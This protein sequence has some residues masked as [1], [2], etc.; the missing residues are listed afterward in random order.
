MN[1]GLITHHWVPNFGANLQAL[2]SVSYLKSLGHTVSVINYRPRD[3]VKVYEGKVSIDQRGLHNDFIKEYFNLTGVIECQ[4][5]LEDK[6]SDYKF[7]VVLSGSDAL[8]R[9]NEKK[10]REDLNFPNP[11]WLKWSFEKSLNIKERGF[12]SVS[13]MG[14]D[15]GKLASPTQEGISELM[16]KFPVISVRDKWTKK[17]LLEL[18]PELNIKVTIDPVFLLDDYFDIPREHDVLENDK[19][20]LIST[21]RF[22]TNEGWIKSFVKESHKMGYKVYALPHPEGHVISEESVDKLLDFPIHPLKWLSYIT[23]AS[24]YVGVRFHPIVISLSN[25]VP[26]VSLD[27]YQKSIFGAKKSKTYDICDKLGMSRYCLGRVK[28]KLYSPHKVVSLLMEQVKGD[29][30]AS[31]Q[32]CLEEEKG[33]LKE[34]ILQAQEKNV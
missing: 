3:M 9:L 27:T 17:S 12:I 1:I 22:V 6:L 21:Y 10:N 2:A 14:N 8:F 24:G 26:F 31:Y 11:F 29:I 5:E 25:G 15:F 33:N 18:N 34:I 16:T 13:N 32:K 30:A 28:R 19:Y 23:Q 20:F 4:E 7:D